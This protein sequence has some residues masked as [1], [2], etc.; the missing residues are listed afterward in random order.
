[1]IKW[2]SLGFWE[3][4]ARIVLRNKIL[5][6]I[7]VV[8]ITVFLGLQWKNIN[9]TYTE[10]NLLPDDN[11]VNIEYNSFLDKFG[12][13]GNLVIIGLHDDVLFTPKAYKAWAEM[14][15]HLEKDPETELVLSVAN[16]KK[17]V[18]NDSTQTFDLKNFVDVSQTADPSYLKKIQKELFNDLPF[19]EGLL[20]NKKSGSI[21]AAIYLDKAIVN[22]PVRK[23]FILKKLIPEI[24][25]F[26]EKTG[27]D[28]RVSGMPYIRTMNTETIKGEIGLFIGMSL[29]IT[30]LLFYFFF[31]SFRATLISLIIVVIGVMW[32][33]GTLGLL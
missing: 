6:L 2:F 24:E 3:L 10:A 15:Q 30:C 27:I 20:F 21:R 25:S 18:K 16:L 28:L 4:V 22:T 29:L 12:E 7:I 1:M 31:R 33:F 23:D 17:L 19:Y 8:L 13:E 14:M 32:S 9:F 11:S 26:K 5:M